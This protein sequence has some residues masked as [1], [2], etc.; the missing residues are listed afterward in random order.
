MRLSNLRIHGLFDTY[1]YQEESYNNILPSGRNDNAKIDFW[2]MFVLLAHATV[3]YKCVPLPK[4]LKPHKPKS[5]LK[6][7]NANFW[8]LLLLFSHYWFNYPATKIITRIIT[9]A[10]N[11]YMCSS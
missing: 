6:E 10:K 5:F 3:N 11:K 2:L 9:V 1:M 8:S 7:D 4:F